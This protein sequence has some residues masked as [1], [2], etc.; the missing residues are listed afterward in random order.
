MKSS[1]KLVE[2]V[3]P[4]WTLFVRC[5]QT[6]SYISLALTRRV[7]SSRDPPFFTMMPGCLIPPQPSLAVLD[8]AGVLQPGDIRHTGVRAPP[9]WAGG[10]ECIRGGKHK[11]I[12]LL[13]HRQLPE[14][15][16]LYVAIPRM[17]S[18]PNPHKHLGS[19]TRK[20]ETSVHGDFAA[21]RIF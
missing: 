3:G 16:P 13:S 11:R 6:S 15:S 7:P 5:G 14:T 8:R 20:P 12:A 19:S 21:W 2:L 9:G 1:P 18:V 4:A 17:S 10:Y